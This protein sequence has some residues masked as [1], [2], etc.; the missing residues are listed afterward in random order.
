MNAIL[1]KNLQSIS[2]FI[3]VADVEGFSKAAK[4]LGVTNSVVSHHVSKLEE[5]LGLT[6]FYRTTRKITLSD[7]GRTLYKVAKS[8]ITELENTISE[9]TDDMS[10]PVGNL[11]I[12][13]PAFMPDPS[14]E[15]KIWKFTHSYP[16]VTIDLEYSDL[17]R[18]LIKEQFDIAFRLG[19]LEDSSMRAIKLADVELLLVASPAFLDSI[20]EINTPESISRAPF[21]ALNQFS[22]V[23][24]F[25]KNNESIR[26]IT[27]QSRIKVDNIF[28][29]RDSAVAGLGLMALPKG[30]CQNALNSG[31]LHRVLSDWRISPIP[32]HALWNNHARR[33]SLTRKLL[34]FISET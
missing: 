21:I 12:A 10:S 29:A 27:R 9:L 2:V 25:N 26:V 28:A 19:K 31:Q 1:Y 33:N 5:S 3:V 6:L 34:T 18:D 4:K 32:L 30:L 7:Q 16:K 22:E 23:V 20:S 14:V 11:R 15:D 17:S 8:T 24:T 13:M